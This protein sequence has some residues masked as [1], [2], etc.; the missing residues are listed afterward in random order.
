MAI[1]PNYPTCETAV[2][3]IPA[4]TF[5]YGSRISSLAFKRQ[6]AAVPSRYNGIAQ[7]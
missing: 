6:I 2:V 3:F 4:L 5:I 7:R 1:F